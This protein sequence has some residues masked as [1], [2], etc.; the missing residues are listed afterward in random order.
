MHHDNDVRD[1]HEWVKKFLKG[2]VKV[3]FQK[4]NWLNAYNSIKADTWPECNS[5]EDFYLLPESIQA[6]CRDVF[7]LDPEGYH[8]DA[9][10]ADIIDENGVEFRIY[11]NPDF[12]PEQLQRIGDKFYPYKS[13]PVKAYEVCN[14]KKHAIL[15]LRGNCINACTWDK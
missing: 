11:P 4:T 8:T 3:V 2:N 13:D 12:Q 10:I 15:L 1:Y 7:K 5:E 14:Q 6:E 9:S